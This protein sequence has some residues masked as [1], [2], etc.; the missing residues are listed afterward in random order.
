MTKHTLTLDDDPLY[1]QI[2]HPV[3]HE[4]DPE[5][6]RLR[7][8][9]RHPFL[10]WLSQHS[11]TGRALKRGLDLLLSGAALLM[12]APVF[13]A[14]AIA[15]RLD[16]RGPIFFRQVR[17]GRGGNEFGFWKFRSMVPNAEALKTQLQKANESPDGVIFKMKNDPR[18]TRVGRFI[19]KFSIDELPQFLNVFMG[20]M[21]I[22][23]PRPPV[24]REVVQYSDDAWRRL[25]IIPGL[26]CIWQVSGRSNIGFRDQV[27]L[28]VRYMLEQNVFTDL[29]LMVLTVPAV[30][31][32]EGAF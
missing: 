9:Y 26:T 32:G 20:Q 5:W 15:I 21:S 23:G 29:R 16:S 31:K 18:V 30:L 17:V 2:L 8:R 25:E 11:W 6:V 24:P 27:R 22:V 13:L 3:T 19:R 12:L 28:D 10:F 4:V 14:T 7:L 1:R